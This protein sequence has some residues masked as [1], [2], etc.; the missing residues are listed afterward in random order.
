MHIRMATDKEYA[1]SNDDINKILDPPTRI[2]TYPELAE[3]ST[4]DDMF[5]E[6]GRCIILYL[7]NGPTSGHWVCMWRKGNRIN[8]FDSYGDAP[9]VPREVVGGAY[10]QEEPYL[11]NLLQNSGCQVYY[12]THPYQSNRADVAS[13]GR[14]CVARLICKDMSDKKYYQLIKRS[15]QS[16]DTFVTNLTGE[17]LKRY[18]IKN[19]INM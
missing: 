10:G 15:G 18:G 11:M 16:P 5:D 8:Y 17:F 2:L 13:C 14:H 1:L 19:K 9:D 7:T 4:V 3:C 6:L 12:N